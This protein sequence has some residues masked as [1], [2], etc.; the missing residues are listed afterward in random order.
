[1]ILAD[2]VDLTVHHFKHGGDLGD[3]WCLRELG[4][5]VGGHCQIGARSLVDIVAVDTDKV[6]VEV[7]LEWPSL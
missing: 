1:M 2:L 6:I 3:L 7:A 5:L 4:D